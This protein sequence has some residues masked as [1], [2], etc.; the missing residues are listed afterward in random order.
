MRLF[1]VVLLA[2]VT[3]AMPLYGSVIELHSAIVKL[4]PGATAPSDAEIAALGGSVDFRFYD[5]L[6]VSVRTRPCRSCV[7]IAE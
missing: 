7:I 4:A 1:R 2:V 5:R 3:M 6:I